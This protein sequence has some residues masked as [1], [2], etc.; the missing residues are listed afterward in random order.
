MKLASKVVS[1]DEQFKIVQL[2]FESI[3]CS[4][5]SYM[6]FVVLLTSFDVFT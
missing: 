2:Q 3:Q 4:L 1:E 6:F 5:L